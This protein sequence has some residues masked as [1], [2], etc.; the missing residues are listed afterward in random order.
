[1]VNRVVDPQ[2]FVE[3]WIAA[4]N[5]R[6]IES[7]VSH[8]VLDVRFT[9]PVAALRIGNPMVEGRAALTSYWLGTKSYKTFVFTLDFVVWDSKTSTLVIVYDRDV[10]GRHSR[11]TEILHFDADGLID[12]GEAMYGVTD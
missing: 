11:A 5:R 9:S 1:M 3:E 12:V 10:D 4:W 7:V 8:F 2:V 6:D